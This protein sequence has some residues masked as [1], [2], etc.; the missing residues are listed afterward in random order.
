MKT[1][2]KEPPYSIAKNGQHSLKGGRES[3]VDDKWLVRPKDATLM[4]MSM[5]CTP[6]LCV[7]GA[8][9]AKH[10]LQYNQS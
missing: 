1:F 8:R 3:V 2:G 4:K 10:S 9:R 7:I 5:S 6:W